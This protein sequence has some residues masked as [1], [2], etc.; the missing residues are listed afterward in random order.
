MLFNYTTYFLVLYYFSSSSP[1]KVR[2]VREDLKLFL[3]YFFISTFYISLKKI[4]MLEILSHSSHF[5]PFLSPKRR[6]EIGKTQPSFFYFSPHFQ[7][8]PPIEADFRKYLL[9]LMCKRS[10]ESDMDNLMR[11]LPIG[12]QTFEDIRRKNILL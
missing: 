9:S 3:F 2:G 10:K 6:R 1:Q 5:L 7:I 12:I 8:S 11:K 4:R